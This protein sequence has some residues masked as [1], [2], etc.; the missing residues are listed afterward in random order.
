MCSLHL[1]PLITHSAFP[2][3]NHRYSL[4][5][6]TT[7]NTCSLRSRSFSIHP[8]STT[9]NPRH[10]LIPQPTFKATN[11]QSP[12]YPLTTH[13]AFPA[14]SSTVAHQSDNIQRVQS[15][16]TPY[17]SWTRLQHRLHKRSFAEQLPS[18]IVWSWFDLNSS[19]YVELKIQIF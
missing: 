4:I 17:S 11:M 12:L 3:Y 19:K 13:P 16:L 5:N 1:H 7:F 2:A 10:L 9:R 6:Q 15:S 8:T 14:W 18:L